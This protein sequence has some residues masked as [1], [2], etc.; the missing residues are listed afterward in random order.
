MI[1][2]IKTPDPDNHFDLTTVEISVNCTG[3]GAP[4]LVETFK[5]FMLAIGY[6]PETV[7]EYLNTEE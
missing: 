7:K 6:G 1:K 4:E 2:F 3:L 5:D